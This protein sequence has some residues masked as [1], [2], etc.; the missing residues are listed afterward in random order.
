L[1]GWP[2]VILLLGLAVIGSCHYSALNF[3]ESLNESFNQSPSAGSNQSSVGVVTLEGEIISSFGT[4]KAL[5]RFE[6]DNNI[7]AVILRLDT[8]GGAVVPCQEIVEVMR[9]MSKPIVVSMGSV[10]ASGGLYLAVAGDH[11]FANP[12]TFTGSIG[13][14]LETIELTGAME[15]LGVKAEA[16]TS[17]KFKDT[18][19]PFRTMRAE[20]K[21]LLQRV[22]LQVY[23]QFVAEVIKG[24][25][26]LTENQVRLLADGRIFSGEEALRL[27][28]VDGL[29]GM[30]QALDKAVTLATGSFDSDN[31]PPMV[32]DDGRGGFWQRL[33]TSNQNFLRPSSLLPQSGLKFLYR[34][35]L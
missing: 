21:E 11:I 14:I 25:P 29:G 4:I 32:Y 1:A 9:T 23:E 6:E 34:P 28:L 12:G 2:L 7:I 31:P 13:V 16:I 5:K 35:G 27:G 3:A 19:S 20:E 17:G 22:V 8:P 26:N 30:D 24:R 33:L 18:G 10:A 15:K